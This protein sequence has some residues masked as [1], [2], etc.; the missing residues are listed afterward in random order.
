MST[1]AGLIL[2]ALGV[3]FFAVGMKSLPAKYRPP[4]IKRGS[5]VET[6]VG[7]IVGA[8]LIWGGALLI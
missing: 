4:F 3:L 1:V 7:W 5:M 8:S 6:V 2:V